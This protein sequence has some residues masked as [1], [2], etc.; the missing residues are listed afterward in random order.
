MIINIIMES[1][2]ILDEVMVTALGIKIESKA[3]E[4]STS[5]IKKTHLQ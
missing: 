5:S 3:L 2:Y 1:D 4:Y